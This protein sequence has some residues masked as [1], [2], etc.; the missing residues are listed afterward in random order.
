MFL[1]SAHDIMI[2][3]NSDNSS[4]LL[5]VLRLAFLFMAAIYPFDCK[6]KL[7]SPILAFASTSCENC[8][9]IQHFLFCRMHFSWPSLPGV[10]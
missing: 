8:N 3:V 5:Y 2:D 6:S 9:V 1:N 4:M 7:L 10:G